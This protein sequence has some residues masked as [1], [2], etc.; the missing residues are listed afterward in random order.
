MEFKR[1]LVWAFGVCSAGVA[2]GGVLP[3]RHS[4]V[5]GLSDWL[6]YSNEWPDAPG[7][8]L[9]PQ[10]LQAL[11]RLKVVW[12]D[13]GVEMALAMSPTKVLT[14]PEYVPKN[15]DI[16]QSMR[17]RYAKLMTA[18]EQRGIRTVD[19]QAAFQRALQEEGGNTPAGLLFYRLDSHWSQQGALV[20]ANAVA[21]RWQQDAVLGRILDATEP[22]GYQLVK[23][24]VSVRGGDD[25][26]QLLPKLKNRFPPERVR[27]L[28]VQ[29]GQESGSAGLTGSHTAP[30]LALVGSSYSQEWTGFPSYLRYSLQREV[31]NF[32]V[33]ATQGTWYAVLRYVSDAAYAANRPKAVLLEIPERE[34]HAAPMYANR[35]ARYRLAPDTWA[36]WVA[37]WAAKECVPGSAPVEIR[38][39]KAGGA[40]GEAV[41][42][43]WRVQGGAGN[44]A[45]VLE[46]KTQA[47]AQNYV[48]LQVRLEKATALRL[49]TDGKGLPSAWEV[50]R[51]AGVWHTIRLPLAESGLVQVELGSD[52]AH[53]DAAFEVR[54]VQVCQ[55]PRD[56]LQ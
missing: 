5:V 13:A 34:M 20:A 48:Q 10:T 16:P 47:N 39:R 52:A 46:L 33:N 44:K 23:G 35:E 42:S 43:V 38:S 49:R 25:L 7:S 29:R 31:A 56:Y 54:D 36:A 41:S 30:A 6:Y 1:A 4:A 9:T 8:D 28:V 2:M 22:A 53:S 14:Y 55:H 37:A 26:T 21:Q 17:E 19:L 40:V 18:L 15:V 27:P 45:G 24:R 3:P 50:T 32:S 11:Q 51:E 12:A